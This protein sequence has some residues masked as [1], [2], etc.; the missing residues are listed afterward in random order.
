MRVEKMESES[1]RYLGFHVVLFCMSSGVLKVL[2]EFV[3]RSGIA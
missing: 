2:M 3:A 1:H